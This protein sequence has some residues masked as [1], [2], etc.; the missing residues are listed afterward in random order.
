MEKSFKTLEI[1]TFKWH[2]YE[3][4]DKYSGFGDYSLL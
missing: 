2:Y 1:F 3:Q 4:K